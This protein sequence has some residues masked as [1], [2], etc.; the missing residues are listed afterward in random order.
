MIDGLQE[1][2][3]AT[4]TPE[5]VAADYAAL[6]GTAPETQSGDIRFRLA[7]MD[8]VLV[9]V[10]GGAAQRTRVYGQI[11][12]DI[13]DAGGLWRA[14]DILGPRTRRSGDRPA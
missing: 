11:I 9:P 14:Q 5:P 12:D 8:F 3:L 4:A 10:D 7:N 2:V 6:F 1:V 13:R